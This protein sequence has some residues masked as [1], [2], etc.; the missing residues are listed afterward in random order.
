M[1]VAVVPV[2]C[3]ISYPP[4]TTSDVAVASV[5]NSTPSPITVSSPTRLSP[6]ANEYVKSTIS[7]SYM[8]DLSSATTLTAFGVIVY[9]AVIT[10][11]L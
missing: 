3:L 9:V 8:L 5:S 7:S 10:V 1:F 6:S 2:F 4:S 11:T